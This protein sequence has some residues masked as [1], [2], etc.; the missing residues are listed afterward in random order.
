MLHKLQSVYLELR[1]SGADGN[2]EFTLQ[3]NGNEQRF[4]TEIVRDVQIDHRMLDS[5]TQYYPAAQA[6]GHFDDVLAKRLREN[7]S[8]AKLSNIISTIQKSQ[9]EII[10]TSVNKSFV[11]QGCAGSGKTQCLIHRLFYLRDALQ[12]TGWRQVLLITPTQLF[13]N[14]S[15]DLMRRYKLNDVQNSSLAGFY[16]SL[17]DAYDPR[18][19]NRQY[20]FELTE[21]FLPDE[22]L[23][24]IYDRE[25]ICEIANEINNA[26]AAH[27]GEAYKLLELGDIPDEINS[28]SIDDLV[29]RL[30]SAISEFDKRTSELSSSAE[31]QQVI[32]D[33]A[34]AQK[35]LKNLQN[36]LTGLQ[37]AAEKTE[38]EKREFEKLLSEYEASEKE[39]TDWLSDKE[40]EKKNI[41]SEYQASIKRYASREVDPDLKRE[42]YRSALARFVDLNMPFGR[43]F[44]VDRET[45][46]I[47]EGLA[48]LAQESLMAYTGGTKADEWQKR[49]A[50][51]ISENLTAQNA[52]T[53]NISTISN[54]ISELTEYATKISDTGENVEKLQP[55]YRAALEKARYYLARIESSVF[56]QEVWNRL[57]PLKDE[58]GI[59][60][61]RVTVEADGHRKQTRILYKSDLLFYLMIYKRLHSSENL[62]KLRLICVDEGQD[63]HSADYTLLRE[64]YPKAVWNVFGDT[65]QVL[66]TACGVSDW[67]KD[68]G[69][70]QPFELN[71]NYR[72]SPAI[73]DFC[74]SEFNSSMDYYGAAEDS[75]DKVIRLTPGEFGAAILKS[76]KVVI[77]KNRESFDCML[78]ETGLSETLF[79]YLDTTSTQVATGKI[80]CYTIFAAKGLEFPDVAVFARDMTQNQKIVAATRAMRT[81]Y[82]CE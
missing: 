11:V 32:A 26:I 80:H 49:T 14:Y 69:I 60:S 74:R 51:R 1:S 46:E 17:L 43:T 73:V 15:R 19:R 23:S 3:V 30:E 70:E 20:E 28:K 4:K 5:V 10:G 71:I 45:R 29:N 25:I 7:K 66:H 68:T 64:L 62:P 34:E 40:T 24:R 6:E 36:R 42:G 50:R 79:D 16:K 56:E 58:Y 9:F 41:V 47:L 35:Q 75:T 76:D 77:V 13:R 27:V 67:G 22:Y 53:A 52:V 31:Y 39:L 55:A 38:T 44:K 12:A 63:L 48:K 57:S 18:F 61:V 78:K 82:Y 65:A 8:D 81:L 54:R 72:N 59:E 37:K 33:L 21:E 2:P